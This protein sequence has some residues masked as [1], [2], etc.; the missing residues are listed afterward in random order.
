M[1][2]SSIQAGARHRTRVKSKRAALQGEKLTFATTV[3]GFLFP[4][5][6]DQEVELLE[7]TVRAN[8]KTR[9]Q[10]IQLLRDCKAQ[11]PRLDIANIFSDLFSDEALLSYNYFG[12]TNRS[13][14]KRAMRDYW[15]FSECMLEA[16]SDQG[17]DQET[18][19]AKLT[20]IISRLNHKLRTR[21]YR[22]KAATNEVLE[23]EMLDEDVDRKSVV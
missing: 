7:A 8:E 6:N 17:I 5:A 22:S 9:E 2:M 19:K 4:L 3:D 10:Y 21:G 18:L 14:K 23:Y 20:K 1:M 13:K 11:C 16:W 12:M 15:I